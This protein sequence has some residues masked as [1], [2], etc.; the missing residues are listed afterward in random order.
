MNSDRSTADLAAVEHQ[1]VGLGPHRAG[2]GF[3]PFEIFVGGRSERVMKRIPAAVIGV[4]L[5][6]REIDHPEQAICLF[7]DQFLAL[8]D[9]EPHRAQAR[10]DGI[11]F[12][13]DH[14]YRVA[15]VGLRG[16]DDGIYSIGPEKLP[17]S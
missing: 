16:V 10:A 13:S 15:D 9:L 3:E 2:I 17:E 6:H 7:V 8:P 1:I 12:A 11:E 14:Q 5:E 4:I